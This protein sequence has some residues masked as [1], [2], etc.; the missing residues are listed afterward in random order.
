MNHSYFHTTL[1]LILSCFTMLSAQTRWELLSTRDKIR[2]TLGGALPTGGAL[3]F[4]SGAGL[5]GALTYAKKHNL[6]IFKNPEENKKLIRALYAIAG[7]AAVGGLGAAGFGLGR[8]IHHARATDVE[9]T[10]LLSDSSPSEKKAQ[11]GQFSAVSNAPTTPLPTSGATAPQDTVKPTEQ[12]KLSDR[13]K[14]KLLI[15]FKNKNSRLMKNKSNKNAQKELRREVRA[16]IKARKEAREEALR[17]GGWLNERSA[18]AAYKK[19]KSE[20][21]SL[22]ELADKNQ[23]ITAE[24]RQILREAAS[25][26]REIA[27]MKSRYVVDTLLPQAI[28]AR[29]SQE[30]LFRERLAQTEAT[31]GK[32]LSK[33]DPVERDERGIITTPGYLRIWLDTVTNK[34]GL[35]AT[36]E[37]EGNWNAML[38]KESEKK[39]AV[40]ALKDKFIKGRKL[41]NN[42][43]REKRA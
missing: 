40:E 37:I 12:R 28:A 13:Q 34:A 43:E 39:K 15:F 27:S 29:E 25:A 41:K 21:V 36:K 8:N 24:E 3:A 11:P 19:A 38:K 26:G 22:Q 16:E 2:E 1:V 9:V 7:G 4:A 5:F 30:T 10:P 33:D 35:N 14:A 17:L 6:G 18:L 20:A 42:L 32:K 31:T 23:K